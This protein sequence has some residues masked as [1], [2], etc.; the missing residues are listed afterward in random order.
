MVSKQFYIC[1]T[2]SMYEYIFWVRYS[3]HFEQCKTILF[4]IFYRRRKVSSTVCFQC[5]IRFDYFFYSV[6]P[7]KFQ[8]FFVQCGT[9]LVFTDFFT[10]WILARRS[11]PIQRGSHYT[12]DL[13]TV[14]KYGAKR[15]EGG[16]KK[17]CSLLFYLSSLFIF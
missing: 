3:G 4:L 12:V 17:S 11:V 2:V 13:Y 6:K 16:L 8:L 15:G 1:F 7:D 10:S 5:G 14:G 9:N